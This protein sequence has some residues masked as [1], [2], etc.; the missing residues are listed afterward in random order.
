LLNA[1]PIF[2][3]STNATTARTSPLLLNLRRCTYDGLAAMPAV[4]LLTPG[5][6]VIAALL[7]GLYR[8]PPV[9]YG[10]IVSMPFWCNFLQLGLTPLLAKI[11]PQ[12]LAYLSAGAQCVLLAA[13]AAAM[14]WLPRE[15]PGR[16]TPWFMALFALLGLT[17]AFAGVG[18]TSWIQ[19]WVPGRLRG[20]YFGSRNQVIQ[21]ATAAF[22]ILIGALLRRNHS[23]VPAFQ[24]VLLGAVVLRILSTWYQVRMRTPEVSTHAQEAKR[25]WREQIEELRRLPSFLWFVAFGAAWGF[26]ANCIGPFYAVFMYQQL[27]LNVQTVSWLTVLTSIGGALSYPAWGALAHR[28]GNKPVIFF[29]MVTWQVQNFL[30]CFLTP[31]NTWILYGMWIFGGV[32]SAGVL[33]GMFNILLKLIPPTAKTAAIS[34]NV[35]IASLVTAVA[36]MIGGWALGH[37]LADAHAPLAVYHRLFVIQP[38]LAILA[39][40]ALLSRV[41]EPQSG[42]LTTVFGAMRNVRT[43]GSIFG[44]TYIVNFVFVKNPKR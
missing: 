39:C 35:A 34:L 31:A 19:E 11:R 41:R 14:F 37:F 18:W 7:T 8:L 5:N 33:L 42:E 30:W 16:S 32:M 10:I 29:G 12:R 38:A 23:S 28:F 1:I 43:L 24:F 13:L 4:F 44:L 36:P 20:K 27:G 6:F 15:D 22:L 26:A 3:V 40:V 9:S 25:P 17:A 21:V 2:R